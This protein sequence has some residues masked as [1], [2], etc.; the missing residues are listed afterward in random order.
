M[1][2]YYEILGVQKNATTD[3]IKK[4]YR[5]LAFKYHPDRNPGD[6]VA[7]EKFKKITEAYDVLGD[8]SKRKMYDMGAYSTNSRTSYSNGSYS[9]TYRNTYSSGNPFEEWFRANESYN[10]GEQEQQQKRYYYYNSNNNSRN[11]SKKT[12]R[13]RIITNIL[14][15]IFVGGA[16]YIIPY[17][18]GPLIGFFAR[19]ICFFTL[20]STI[21]NLIGDFT[22][23]KYAKRQ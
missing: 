22:R 18:F 10:S 20:I 8:E 15:I 3:E 23:L 16:G 5:N 19:S 14:K 12:I 21:I 6:K 4:A 9:N 7:E 11:Y 2:N 1:E 17:I 13:K